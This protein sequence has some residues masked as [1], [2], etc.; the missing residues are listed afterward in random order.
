MRIK[1]KRSLSRGRW[2]PVAQGLAQPCKNRCSPFVYQEN[3]S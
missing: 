3:Y 2:P 1:E